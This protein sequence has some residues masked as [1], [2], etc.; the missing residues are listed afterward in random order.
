MEYAVANELYWSNAS[1]AQTVTLTSEQIADIVKEINKVTGETYDNLTAA[2][3]GVVALNGNV[4]TSDGD[5]SIA[6]SGND[7]TLLLR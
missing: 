7:V 2:L 4:S 3:A 5:V 1:A 6:A